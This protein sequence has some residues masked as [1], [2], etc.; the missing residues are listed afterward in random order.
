MGRTSFSHAE[1]GE[2]GGGITT[3]FEAVSNWRIKNKIQINRK[4]TK[5]NYVIWGNQ[6]GVQN[7]EIV[8]VWVS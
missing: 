2:G 1:G 8:R 5:H 4:K 6:K 7:Q 3:S